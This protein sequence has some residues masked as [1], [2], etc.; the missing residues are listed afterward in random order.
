MKYSKSYRDYRELHKGFDIIFGVI[1]A[2][3]GI[4]GIIF[5]LSL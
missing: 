4:A 3:I 1:S 5:F 2:V